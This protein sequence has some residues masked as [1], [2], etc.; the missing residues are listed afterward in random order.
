MV[1]TVPECS[2]SVPAWKAVITARSPEPQLNSSQSYQQN[3]HS[4]TH[5]LPASQM[6][7]ITTCPVDCKSDHFPLAFLI[8][9]SMFYS[10]DSFSHQ[11]VAIPGTW[12]CLDSGLC[13]V[14]W[15]KVRIAT[16]A[17]VWPELF[18]A[19]AMVA[20][21]RLKGLW[22]KQRLAIIL[23]WKCRKELGENKRLGRLEVSYIGSQFWSALPPPPCAAKMISRIHP[24]NIKSSFFA[25]WV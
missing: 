4:M 14:C 1:K 18:S 5:P 9:G 11:I 15:A 7:M 23:V 17:A 3:Y 2:R 13:Y 20:S 22:N 10:R 8:F 21:W 24:V 6:L 19:R 12:H 25:E 16:S